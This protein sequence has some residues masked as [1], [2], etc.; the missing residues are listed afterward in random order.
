MDEGVSAV[1]VVN[2]LHV[3]D[4]WVVKSVDFK[5]GEDSFYSKMNE[6]FAIN[7][8]KIL[9]DV[10]KSRYPYA[11]KALYRN[12][13]KIHQLVSCQ[14]A[15]YKN[16]YLLQILARTVIEHF[17]VGH[18]IFIRTTCE[19]SDEAGREFYQEYAVAEFF[20]RESHKINVK[21]SKLGEKKINNAEEIIKSK[22]QGLESLSLEEVGNYHHIAKQF[23]VT[24]I[25]R[26]LL[27]KDFLKSPFFSRFHP[28][29]EKLVKDYNFL[30]SYIHGGPSAELESQKFS[31]EEKV[32]LINRCFEEMRLYSRVLKQ[33][34]LFLLVEE[35]KTYL[36]LLKPTIPG[37][38]IILN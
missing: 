12:Q 1:S 33:H 32:L 4:I 8:D 34:L 25:F 23:E 19:K 22:L 3:N 35:D 28:H 13:A 30:S 17:L 16:Y 38:E 14:L 27:S 21:K 5:I 36:D 15:N 18:Y 9:E 37:L 2:D 31:D 7:E 6:V 20:K 29:I 24:E 10:G 11:A 26:R